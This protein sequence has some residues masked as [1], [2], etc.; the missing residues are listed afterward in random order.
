MFNWIIVLVLVAVGGYFLYHSK[1]EEGWNWQA[2]VAAL[3]ALG[4]AVGVW[5]VDAWN[6]IVGLF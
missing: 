2:G 1:T 5:F 6:W 3:T 4:T